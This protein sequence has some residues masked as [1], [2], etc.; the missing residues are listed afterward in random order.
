[1]TSIIYAKYKPLYK[2]TL[3]GQLIGYVKDKESMQKM[4]DNYKND[5]HE[6]IAYITLNYEPNYELEFVS[7]KVKDNTN[8]VL[9][10]I[11][12]NSVITY[13]T[14]AI[15]H[16][17]KEEIRVNTEA[18]AKEIVNSINKS[19][20]KN[21][22]ITEIYSAQN[23]AEED[24]TPKK[25]AISKLTTKKN[26]KKV[27]KKTTS[28][29]SISRVKKTSN[30]TKTVRVRKI[31]KEKRA[32]TR[33]KVST[34]KNISRKKKDVT[35]NKKEEVENTEKISV[36]SGKYAFPVKGCSLKNV[37][38][39]RYPSYSGH[40][41]IDVNINVK[42]KSVVAADDGV[43]IKSKAI[44]S[45][46]GAYRSYGECIMIR[47]SDGKVTLYAHMKE[48]SRRVFVGDKVRRGQVIGKVGSTGNSTGKHLHFEVQIKGKP[49][50]PFKYL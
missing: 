29:S 16:N 28:R 39:K 46:S 17:G 9:S 13:R 47:H 10:T 37:R 18:E 6:N 40:T 36:S 11:K 49:V 41:G 14:Y 23:I 12:N 26:T 2:V 24:I 45:K 34:R 33:K 50:N 30:V 1:M 38:S 31:K 21:I 43:V 7:S 27:K 19:D 42:G 44:R 32:K 20:R 25:M 15:S 48:D 4:I 35:K 5:I 22:T 3:N 8:E